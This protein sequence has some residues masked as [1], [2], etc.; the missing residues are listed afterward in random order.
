MAGNSTYTTEQ[1]ETWDN[2]ALKV[3]GSEKYAYFLMQNNYP[4]L[5]ILVFSAGT[6]LKTPPLPEKLNGSLPPW[7]KR[8]I[9]SSR[10][11]YDR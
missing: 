5:D 1:G 7:R 6:L 2:I 8:T 9:N 10:D 11:P 3:Y 4:S